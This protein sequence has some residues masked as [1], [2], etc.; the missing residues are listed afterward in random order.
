[1]F[2]DGEEEGVE[3]D[4]VAWGLEDGLLSSM[5]R[6]QVPYPLKTGRPSSGMQLEGCLVV[7]LGAGGHPSF[8]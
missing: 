5:A 4:R 3:E 7:W 2:G 8:F 6:C 1:M